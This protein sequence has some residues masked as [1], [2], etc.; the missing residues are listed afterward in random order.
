MRASSKIN[1][2]IIQKLLNILSI[3]PY[4]S[5]FRSLWHVPTLESLHIVIKCDV[6]LEQRV[7]NTLSESQVAAI[8]IENNDF[9][10]PTECDIIVHGH[11]GHSHRVQYYFGCYD[12]LQYPLLFSY[13]DT[14]W[15]QGIQRL[16]QI[17][18]TMYCQGQTSLDPSQ[19][20]S[21]DKLLEREKK[22]LMIY[23]L[24]KYKIS[25]KNIII[26][27]FNLFAVMQR[28]LKRA[29]LSNVVSIIAINRKYDKIQL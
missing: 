8:W 12:P 13:G 23:Y 16:N 17:N 18:P 9:G 26:I 24:L 27:Y 14:G 15:H 28:R 22:V 5:F 11:S 20:P 6:W 10:S 25:I 3:N 2:G 29:R 1:L 4:C 21:I 7:Y 19:I